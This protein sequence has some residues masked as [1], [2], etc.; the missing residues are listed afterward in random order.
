[1][2]KVST[3]NL[4]QPARIFKILLERSFLKEPKVFQVNIS[5][6]ESIEVLRQT[7]SHHNNY[8][9]DSS[10]LSLEL[11]SQASWEDSSSPD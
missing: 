11:L 2:P 10:A 3:Q 1:M 8:D 5:S 4:S 7:P 6:I 9:T